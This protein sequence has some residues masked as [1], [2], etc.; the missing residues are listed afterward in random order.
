[1]QIRRPANSKVGRIGI[2][3]WGIEGLV[4]LSNSED[5]VSVT[6]D[7]TKKTNNEL[8]EAPILMKESCTRTSCCIFSIVGHQTCKPKIHGPTPSTDFHYWSCYHASQV[9]GRLQEGRLEVPEKRIGSLESESFSR[10]EPDSPKI[11]DWD[12]KT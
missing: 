11:F 7:Q 8:P 1:M 9:G 12:T 3:H 6:F 10:K 5:A 4:I 2:A